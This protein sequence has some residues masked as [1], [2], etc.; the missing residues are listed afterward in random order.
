MTRPDPVEIVALT[1]DHLAEAVVVLGCFVLS[2]MWFA[3]AA[4]PVPV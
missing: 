1:V 2:A 3:I 4:T